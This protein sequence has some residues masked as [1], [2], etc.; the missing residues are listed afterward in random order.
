[1]LNK[2]LLALDGSPESETI[3]PYVA[4]LLA[5]T[6]CQV[7]L[8]IVVKEPRPQGHTRIVAGGVQVATGQLENMP[9]QEQEVI[10]E[11]ETEDQA[12]ERV[13]RLRGEYLQKHVDALRARQVPADRIVLLGDDVPQTLADFGKD[14]SFDAIAMATHGREGLTR[15]FTGSV[16]GKV[17]EKAGVPVI[18]VRGTK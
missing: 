5:K 12:I 13:Q 17:V 15:L 2:L 9:F 11:G 4:N 16:A 18:L 3:I 8:A 10:Y 7:T 6:M 14:G 1:M